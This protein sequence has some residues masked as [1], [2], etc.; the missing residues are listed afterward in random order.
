MFPLQ[1][2]T[3]RNGEPLTTHRP[4]GRENRRRGCIRIQGELGK[5]GTDTRLGHLGAKDPGVN[6]VSRTTPRHSRWP[7]TSTTR[8]L[9]SQSGHNGRFVGCRTSMGGAPIDILAPFTRCAWG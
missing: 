6:R 2:C 7:F 4:S 3:S 8:L 1:I 5:L 9:Y